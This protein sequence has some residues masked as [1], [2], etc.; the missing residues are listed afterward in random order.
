MPFHVAVIGGGPSGLMAADILSA[1]GVGVTVHDRMPSLGRKFLLAGRGGLNL[2]HSEELD[3][4][5]ARYGSARARLEPAIRRF[6]PADTRALSESLG[7]PTFIG[8]SGRVFPKAMKA[9]PLLRAWLR[10]LDGRGVRFAPRHR[11]TG[12]TENGALLFAG[13]AGDTVMVSADATILALGGASWPKLGSDGGW[14]APL[15]KAGVAVAPLKPANCGF[16]VQWSARMREQFEGRP[17][18]RVRLTFGGE[19]A[20][21]DAIVTRE[22]IEGGVVYAMSAVL[23]DAIEANREALLHIDLRPDLT[24]I[25]LASRLA[26]PRGKMSL[27]NFLRKAAGLSPPAI[28]LLHEAYAGAVSKM[29]A[30]ELATLIKAVPLRLIATAPLAR[31]ISTAGGVALEEVDDTFMLR[32]MP[33]VFVAGEMLDWEAPTGG[34]LLQASFATGAAAARGVL[35]FLKRRRAETMR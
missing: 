12:F 3:R 28:A 16:Q 15:R 21:G 6:S 1:A 2:T 29:S 9:S 26:V 13:A 5:L 34:Y 19:T 4:F 20:Q 10:R 18:K 22:G 23:R 30:A 11:W 17:L 25:D 7:Q 8:T 14:V 33:G 35:E 32:K 24:E 27:S 31:A